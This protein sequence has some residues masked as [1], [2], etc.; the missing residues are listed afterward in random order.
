[1]RKGAQLWGGHNRLANLQQLLQ[2]STGHIFVSFENQTTNTTDIVGIFSAETMGELTM[3]K[4]G[5]W[6]C[7]FSEW[8]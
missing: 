4:N 1:M 8:H 2:Q 5:K 3:Q 6:Q 7:S